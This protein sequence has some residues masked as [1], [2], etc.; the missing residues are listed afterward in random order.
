VNKIFVSYSS[1]D[2]KIANRICA[3][4]E[5]KGFACWIASRDINP[6]ENF[7][8]AIVKAIRAAKLM[9]LVFTQNA[10]NSD[11]IKKE[12]VLAGHNRLIVVPVRVE[13]VVPGG[14]FAY[15]LATRQWIDLFDD[16]DRAME[17]LASWIKTISETPVV[18][19]VPIATGIE[20]DLARTLAPDTGAKPSVA[21]VRTPLEEAITPP[22]PPLETPSPPTPTPA[23]P[24]P[25]VKPL[26]SPAAPTPEPAAPTRRRILRIGGAL[27]GIA[28]VGG[29]TALESQPGHRLWRLLYDK[30]IRTYDGHTDTVCSVVVLPDGRTALSGSYDRTLALWDVAS[31]ARLRTFGGHSDRVTSVALSPDGRTAVSGS[32]DKTVRLWDVATGLQRQEFDADTYVWSVAVA[33]GGRIALSGGEGNF[34]FWDMNAG[35]D[36]KRPVTVADYVYSAAF[37]PDGQSVLTSGRTGVV[38]LWTAGREIRAFEGHSDWVYSVAF[39]PD[40][41]IAASGSN[42]RT[43]KLWDVATGKELRTLSGPTSYVFSVAFTPDGGTLLSGDGDDLLRFWDVG[44]GRELRSLVGH[45]GTVLSVAASPDGRFVLSGSADRTL[46]LWDLSGKA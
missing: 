42:D 20:H 32:A 4:L 16:W 10:N 23:P 19:P 38:R 35:G 7:G 18:A 29:G 40:G 44:S 39:S 36:R 28:V 25:P 46:K 5:A 21:P 37:S 12:L 6:G 45:S 27:A 3:A 13:D 30:S 17:R 11:E 15:E 9:L 24:A 43:I 22:P 31:G 26:A 2:S 1:K 8:E 34:T 41:H 14:A 33:P